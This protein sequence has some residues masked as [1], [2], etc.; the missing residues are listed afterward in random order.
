MAFPTFKVV[1][2]YEIR[3]RKRLFVNY[4]KHH[5]VV[6][7]SDQSFLHMKTLKK[8]IALPQPNTQDGNFKL[9]GI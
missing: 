6:K 5:S 7:D 3:Y 1:R 2:V 4:K 8:K 9:K